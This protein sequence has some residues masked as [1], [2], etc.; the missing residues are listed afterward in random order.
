MPQG[1]STPGKD[2]TKVAPRWFKRKWFLSILCALL[3]IVAGMWAGKAYWDSRFFDGYDPGLPTELAVREDKTRKDYRRE[4]FT[5]EARPGDRVPVLAA[6]P[7]QAK[8][9]V[10]CV[11]MLY[12]I[13]QKKEFLDEIAAPF[14]RKGFALVMPEQ[15][16]RGERK[17]EGM[18]TVQGY[19][20][21]R[22]RAALNVLET[23]RLIDTL[24]AHKLV[25]P[26]RI[27]LWGLSFGAI[28]GA[29]VMVHEPRLK[30]AVFSVGG[31]DLR[32]ML[33]ESKQLEDLGLLR[34]PLA[35]ILSSLLKPIEPVRYVGQISPRPILM[36]NA[37]R[38]QV[39]PRACA[40]ALHKAANDPKDI[41]WYDM[42]H[43]GSG[44]DDVIKIFE[45]GVGWLTKH[46]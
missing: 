13:G 40:E 4:L 23:R 22:R 17:V 12:G 19:L 7:L 42:T 44:K 3:V 21:L 10:P 6:F 9:P 2:D 29:S 32:R 39:I 33:G 1:A 26:D 16:T 11:V 46:P 38:D 24:E 25:D 14:T 20:S 43:E 31:G 45:D 15:Y 18:G 34:T 35:L 36:Q 5:F 37:L 41:V 28:C 8:G 27:Y 30:A